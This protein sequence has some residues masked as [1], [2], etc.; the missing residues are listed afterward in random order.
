MT[1]STW[2]PFQSPEVK[3]ICAHLTPEE[4][5]QFVRQARDN[6]ARLGNRFAF[7]AVLTGMSFAYSSRVGSVLLVFCAI[8]FL[9][10]GLP[11]LRKMRDRTRQLLCDTAWAQ[12]HGYTSEKLRLMVFPWNSQR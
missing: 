11:T 3:E 8:Y 9:V 6:G 2:S 10:V 5:E 7:P 1:N 12:S 4:Q